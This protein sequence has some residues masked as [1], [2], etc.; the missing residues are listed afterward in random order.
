MPVLSALSA[1]HAAGIRHLGI[2]PDTLHIMK[3]G[4]MKLDGFCIGAVRRMNSDLP[5]DLVAG[6]AAMEQYVMDYLP[7]EATDVYG[8]AASLFL[9]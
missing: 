5:P 9:P 6:C 8:F 7:N 1:I 2:S 4:R 3:D